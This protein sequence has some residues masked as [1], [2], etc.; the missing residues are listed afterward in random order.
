MRKIK[1][2]C[3]RDHHF[4]DLLFPALFVDLYHRFDHHVPGRFVAGW[5]FYRGSRFQILPAARVFAGHPSFDFESFDCVVDSFGYP[6][7]DLDCFDLV[8]LFAGPNFDPEN[9]FPLPGPIAAHSEPAGL[10]AAVPAEPLICLADPDPVA[11]YAD[12]DHP[13]RFGDDPDFVAVLNYPFDFDPGDCDP[14]RGF[15]DCP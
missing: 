13:A 10:F 14:D 2:F 9:D 8:D 4:G 6:S 3:R 7:F 15:A 11:G 1:S 12:V 5:Y